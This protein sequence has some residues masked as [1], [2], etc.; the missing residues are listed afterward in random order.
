MPARAS[1]EDPDTELRRLHATLLAC[2]NRRDAAGFAALFASNGNTIGFDGSQVDG[3]RA[4]EAHLAGVFG[5]HTPA[6]YVAVVR[7]V[8]SLGPVSALLRAVA[9]MVPPGQS[10]LNPALNT[11]Q[12]L[13]AT[14]DGER[15][16]I[17]L[18]HNTPAALHGR[19]EAVAALTEELQ[20]QVGDLAE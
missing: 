20:R 7:E 1:R 12:S 16:S 17:E 13:V 10:E 18:F 3:S 2:W 15:W 5:D 19:P 8:R 9:G 14:H 11:I 6:R 4:I